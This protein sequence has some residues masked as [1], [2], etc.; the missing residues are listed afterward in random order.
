MKSYIHEICNESGPNM[1]AMKSVLLNLYF[2]VTL[3]DPYPLKPPEI[4]GTRN[5]LKKNFFGLHLS[6]KV[7]LYLKLHLADIRA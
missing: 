1:A 7:S 2:L 4:C 6:L 3:A 5:R